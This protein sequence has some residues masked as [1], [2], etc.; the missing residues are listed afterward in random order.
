M[1]ELELSSAEAEDVGPQPPVPCDA[2][3]ALEPEAEPFDAP[4]PPCTVSFDTGAGTVSCAGLAYAEAAGDARGGALA[5]AGLATGHAVWPAGLLL[6]DYLVSLR[7]QWREA[8]QPLRV[9]ELGCGLG[10][11]GLVAAKLLPPLSSVWLTDGDTGCCARAAANVDANGAAVSPAVCRV[12]PLVWGDAAADARL[13]ADAGGPF[14]VVLAGDCVYDDGAEGAK[15]VAALVATASRLLSPAPGSAFLIGFQR[16]TLPLDNLLRAATGVGLVGGV[17]DGCWAEDF[18]ANRCPE[19][20]H[21]ALSCLTIASS[22]PHTCASAADGHVADGGAAARAGTAMTGHL[23]APAF[24]VQLSIA[25][26]C[27]QPP[28]LRSTASLAA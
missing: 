1:P 23:C 21:G 28:P 25:A 17:P 12:R 3:A 26:Q 11:C 9:V 10:L 8:A 2:H 20:R 6:C 15:R 24:V 4:P 13:V 7:P 27:L 16:R 18:F 22:R 14:D 5:R 19:A